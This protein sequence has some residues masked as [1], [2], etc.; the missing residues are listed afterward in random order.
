MNDVGTRARFATVTLRQH[1]IIDIAAIVAQTLTSGRGPGSIPSRSDDVE[2]GIVGGA[3]PGRTSRCGY[4]PS[5]SRLHICCTPV[6]NQPLIGWLAHSRSR[7]SGMDWGA[8][9]R[10]DC[11][12]RVRLG[13]NPASRSRT[14]PSWT[15]FTPCGRVGGQFWPVVTASDRR[16]RRLRWAQPVGAFGGMLPRAIARAGRAHRSLSPQAGL[17]APRCRLHV[18]W[19]ATY[20][21]LEH[22]GET[23]TSRVTA[24]SPPLVDR[25]AV[26]AAEAPQLMDGP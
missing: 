6:T 2:N 4:S 18:A 25:H 23:G 20:G 22:A 21:L 13:G 5:S 10:S 7:A 1:G 14:R 9:C 3:E 17:R 16:R 8:A 15:A 11:I 19:C 26:A 12:G 24:E